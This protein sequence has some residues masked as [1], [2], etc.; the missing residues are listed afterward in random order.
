VLNLVDDAPE[1][2]ARVIEEAA[3][4]LGAPPPP[5]VP[6]A[7]AA[8]TMSPM[9]RGFWSENRKVRSRG[10]QAALGIAWRYPDYRAGLRAILAE[11]RGHRSAQ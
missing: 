8:E 3:Q 10:T 1:E 5:A 2:S 7:Q 4:L 9:A 11:E 6:F